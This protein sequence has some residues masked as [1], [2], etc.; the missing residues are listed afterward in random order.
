MKHLLLFSLSL[1]LSLQVF[2]Q[3]KKEVIE[4]GIQVK[5]NYEQDLSDGDKTPYLEK[6]EFYNFRGDLIEIKEYKNEGKTVDIWIKYKYDTQGN[7]IEEIVLDPKGEQEER[8]EYTYEG[9]LKT[10]KLYYDSKNRLYK[11]KLYKYE[12]RK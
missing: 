6:E 12:L 2:A 1:Y 11:K 4:Y 3:D 7:L 8:Y 5:R 9:G 10:G